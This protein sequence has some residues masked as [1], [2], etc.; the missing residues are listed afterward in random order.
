MATRYVAASAAGT[1][2]GVDAANAAAFG[3]L[4][5]MI[6]EAGPGG[7]VTI[8]GDDPIDR[9]G[10]TV[11]LTNG[12]TSGNPV[13][14]RHQ[15]ADGSA[16]THRIT[17][18]RTDWTKPADPEQTT[19]VSLWAPGDHLFS[20]AADYLTFDSLYVGRIGNVF[21][22]PGS[23][24]GLTILD[25][26]AY[27]IRRLLNTYTGE[28][29]ISDIEIRRPTIIGFSDVCIRAR[30]NGS[31]WRL[32]GPGTMDSARQDKDNFA[33]GF[34]IYGTVSDVLV[35]DMTIV[36][37]HDTANN[38]WNGDGV[39]CEEFNDNIVIRRCV[40]TG[41]TDA[42]VDL[43]GT[44]CVV[45]DTTFGDSKHGYRVWN[46]VHTSRRNTY[47]TMNKRGGGG[48][49]SIIGMS[50]NADT[51]G[52]V[53]LNSTDDT[54]IDEFGG[55]SLVEYAG[56]PNTATLNIEGATWDLHY[57]TEA[58][59]LSNGILEGQ[60]TENIEPPMQRGFPPNLISNPHGTGADTGPD[61]DAAGAPTGW[62]G[63]GDQNGLTLR[64][65]Y[66]S[67]M[68]GNYLD[69]TIAG[70]ATAG[71]R[72]D[73]ETC[74]PAEVPA[75]TGE[76]RELFMVADILDNSSAWD[77]LY[78][79]AL[80]YDGSGVDIRSG[81]GDIVPQAGPTGYSYVRTMAEAA[82]EYVRMRLSLEYSA[83]QN[84][85]IRF[86]IYEAGIWDS[87]GESRAAEYQSVN[88]SLVNT[89]YARNV[90]AAS[91]TGTPALGLTH[92]LSAASV[93]SASAVSTPTLD[94]A[95]TPG[96]VTVTG[97]PTAPV[98]TSP[99]PSWRVLTVDG[100][101]A[102]NQFSVGAP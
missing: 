78:F 87:T 49:C 75:L 76:K 81:R 90:E 43:K 70:T 23:C 101:P 1:G 18:G 45:E 25:I 36:N 4:N 21:D 63:E 12:G 91:E 95:A 42:G 14:I 50:D 62:E 3:D 31:N 41:H 24:T 64:W 2:S 83:G 10:G 71:S 53:V 88:Y 33:C 8:L 57:L 46:Q 99:T 13:T 47:Q 51:S 19:D 52:A 44:N 96:A 73:I 17:A 29:D 65:A 48:K 97:S 30:G 66:G 22:I 54:F 56:T 11:T 38:Y 102:N 98:E 72:I 82:T 68:I 93:Q 27:N 61:P 67:D 86:R 55:V 79:R 32:L 84:L 100:D 28:F 26:D 80:E 59:D 34:G 37:C 77:A 35:E 7:T 58:R 74:G 85:D 9:T 5:T 92:P 40:L 15:D 20:V 6:G 94:R 60:Y 89:L 39:S 69:L 16:P